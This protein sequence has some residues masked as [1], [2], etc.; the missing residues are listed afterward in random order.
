MSTR[1]DKE[2]QQEQE[3]IELTEVVEESYEP[4][5]DSSTLGKHDD[6]S[7]SSS[8]QNTAVHPPRSQGRTAEPDEDDFD[9]SSLVY[10]S[11]SSEAG[12]LQTDQPNTQKPWNQ[13]AHLGDQD[14]DD[15]EDLFDELDLDL[16]SDREDSL[17]S[18]D[19]HEGTSSPE[20]Q[21]QALNKP[22]EDLA[23]QSA[24][25]ARLQALESRITKLEQRTYSGSQE[26]WKE[27]EN[28]ILTRLEEMVQERITAAK[29]ALQQE[30]ESAGQA[31][32]TSQEGD[33][34]ELAQKV[35]DINSYYALE[36]ETVSA[37]KNELWAE[38][39]Q[40]IEETVPLAAARIIRQEIQALGEEE[41][42][43]EKDI[44]EE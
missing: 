22:A 6:R 15:L 5:A 3:I 27:I 21:I 10:D 17:G 8:G 38:L 40:R 23:S 25:Q 12:G 24:D 28:R 18:R 30:I 43:S 7:S 1:S 19:G 41:E 13:Q 26:S 2:T 31:N 29:H 37:L 39:S 14:F 34:R 32:A 4:T 33:V 20:D 44:P 36:P 42:D 35:E 11:K 9:F 16:D